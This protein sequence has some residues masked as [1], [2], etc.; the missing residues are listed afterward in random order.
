MEFLAGD[1][2]R[3]FEFFSDMDEKDKIA[4][5]SHTDLDGITSAILI[6]R[7]IGKINYLKF[8]DYSENMLEKIIPEIKKRKINKIIFSDIAIDNET[9][10]IDEINKLEKILIIDHHKFDKDLN[11]DKIVYIKTESKIPPSYSC[12]FLL[13]KIQNLERLDWLSAMAITAD[14]CY[15][16]NKDFVDDIKKKY[17]L[18]GS[19]DIRKTKLWD[20]SCN[21][22][23]FLIYFRE[24]MEEAFDILSRTELTNLNEIYKYTGI[25]K[26]EIDELSK[27]FYKEREP[28]NYGYYW[29][30][31]PKFKIKSYL[32]NKLS[33]EE[34]NKLFVF[35]TKEEDLLRISLRKQDG[36][37]DCDCIGRKAIEGLKNASC[38]GHKAAAGGE[39]KPEDE[40]KFKDNLRRLF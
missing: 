5:I 4:L 37:L 9:K 32:I 6:S 11:S 3:F 31:K 18:N 8:I 16:T 15:E 14:W 33:S 34:E 39:I 29:N 10:G 12:Y 7:I 40:L 20:I 28:E 21:L 26:K 30:F 27:R 17:N 13:S 24:N 19:K 23:L 1:E 38:G 2:K 36:K 22:S 35:V 25:V